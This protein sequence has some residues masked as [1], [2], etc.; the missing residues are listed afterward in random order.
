MPAPIEEGS[1]S[2]ADNEVQEFFDRIHEITDAMESSNGTARAEIKEVWDEAA[3]ELGFTKASLK[4]MFGE[5]RRARKNR[6]KLLKMDSRDRE[7]IQK[8]ADAFGATG[9]GSWLADQAAKIPEPGS[10]EGGHDDSGGEE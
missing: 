5:Q 6:A 2:G 8:A 10:M 7:S 3:D 4:F 9:F 1:N